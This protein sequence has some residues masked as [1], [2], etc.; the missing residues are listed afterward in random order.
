MIVRGAVEIQDADPSA[1]FVVEKP[2]VSTPSI[3]SPIGS[4]I[5]SAILLALVSWIVIP[6]LPPPKGPGLDASWSIGLNL[7]HVS[8]MNFGRDIAFTYGPL[9]YLAVPTFPEAEP[10]AVFALAW[11]MALITGW[12]LWRIC[13]D[14]GHWITICLYLGV[15]WACD[16]FIL[17][18]ATERMLAAIVAVALLLAVRLD[19]KPWLELGLLFF[20]SGFALLTKFNIGFIGS[21]LALYF[22]AL[23]LVRHF[24]APRRQWIPVVATLLCWPATLVLLYWIV[25]GTPSGLVQFLRNSADVALGYSEAMAMPGP[26]WVA[27]AAVLSCA[28]L[29]IGVPLLANERRRVWCAVPPLV[30]IGFLCF[31][32]AMVRQD[33]HAM[34][35]PFE[36][37]MAALLVVAW[38]NTRRNRI[39][40]GAFS[41]AS[42]ALGIA[43]TAQLWP[44]LLP[45]SLERHTAGAVFRNLS[46]FLHW[47]TT[48]GVI[49]AETRQNLVSEQLPAEF[50]PYVSGKTVA[51]YPWE[52]ALIKA[53]H[54]RWQ[55]LP[56]FQ[57]YVAYTPVLDRLNAHQLIG[58][59]SG[60]QEILFSWGAID[61][62]QMSYE[63]PE[64]WRALLNWYDIQ[65][66]TPTWYVL[67]RRSTPRFDS[68][69]AIAFS[70]V[71]QWGQTIALPPFAD[72]EA[73]VMYADIGES[74]S[75]IVKRT[76]F[77]SPI[78][79]VRV[80][81]QSGR[82]DSGRVLPAN[83]QNGVIVSQWP[84]SVG[85]L[86][87]M[88]ESGDRVQD[89][90]VAISFL[91]TRPGE[92]D[93][94]IRL[95]WSRMK[96][97][98]HVS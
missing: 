24:P 23:L 81:L 96:S 26:F 33:R 42:L 31:K 65:F 58:D 25:E 46:G 80:T 86:G 2:N 29:W 32:H 34:P 55:P 27:A 53:N 69:V 15:F 72:D 7:A 3:R 56:V 6:P 57:E 51:I 95:R 4:L 9:G 85:D 71:A 87:L 36:I 1:T 54:L 93:P 37:A 82:T 84:R 67:R 63:T 50:V 70:V 91:T 38:A 10:W 35:F 17:G 39:V 14:A 94:A 44:Q 66:T 28:L 68:P 8:G 76:L 73:L 92:F 20:L 62:R 97:R 48:V 19:A 12:A 49:E 98:R 75:G 5:K 61:G 11:G 41:V 79:Q 30:L 83:L 64:T 13:Q 88:L 78:V 22:W 43:T 77:R 47:K 90:V 40:V 21:G 89:R 16:V 59:A 74:L 52:T 60:P 18:Q 45:L